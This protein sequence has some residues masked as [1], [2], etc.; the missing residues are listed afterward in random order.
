MRI[1]MLA[2]LL[3]VLQV[4]TSFANGEQVA[5]RFVEYWNIGEGRA[6]QNAAVFSE[7][8]IQR[9]GAQGLAGIMQMVYQDNGDIA[10]HEVASSD[11][12][13]I[14]FIASSQKGN[15]LEIALDIS[16]DSKVAG[17][18]IGMV[19]P[20]AVAEDTGLTDD[21]IVA[22]LRQ[23]M[24]ERV[25]NDEFSGSVL[26]ARNGEVLFGE[27]YGKADRQ[28]GVDN[29][30]D[31]PF[32]L[33]SMNK[34]FTGLA[35]AQLVAEGKL[36]YG[37]S[38][39][40]YLPDYP[41]EQLRDEVTIHQLLT[42]TSGMGSYWNDAYWQSK[43]SLNSVGDFDDLCSG[44]P[45]EAPPG[46]DFIYSNC[47][48]VVLGLVIEAVSGQNY[49]DYVR[50]HI[51]TPAGMQHSGH[52]SKTETASGKATGYFVPPGGK[53]E[54][55]ISNFDDLGRM[56]SP[57]GGGYASAN[58]LL[59]FSNALFDGRLIDAKGLE[60]L[61]TSKTLNG[62]DW[63]YGYLFIDDR[64]GDQRY[65]GHNGGAPGINA[66][67]SVFPDKGYT[68]IVLSNTNEN[69]TPVADQIRQWVGHSN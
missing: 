38:V 67:F 31:T 12:E 7:D 11:D 66:E 44:Q 34:M 55:L 24:D 64:I 9:R 63:G 35:I 3:Y 15:W 27:A 47:G 68:V 28:S 1:I 4:S 52:F 25:A 17:M 62:Q 60:E 2:G 29:T 42:H 6:E 49:F 14:V 19:P 22:R 46:S 18:G 43:D 20:P 56:G 16:P 50:D 23:Y 61:T 59:L 33:G 54:Q 30:L 5:S 39:G 21:Q 45:L 40:K 65:T 32:N 51:Y 53:T 8:F 57:A 10:I 48:P 41:N 69:A 13:Q 37:D 58:D 36:A 26:L